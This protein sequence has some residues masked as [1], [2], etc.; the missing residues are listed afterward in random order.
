MMIERPNTFDVVTFSMVLPSLGLVEVCRNWL[1][2]LK[3]TLKDALRLVKSIA[4][5]F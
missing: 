5:T 4:E 3:D 2:S 1:D